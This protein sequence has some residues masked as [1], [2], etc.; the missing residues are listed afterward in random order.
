MLMSNIIN[1]ACHSS[2]MLYYEFV[3]SGGICLPIL[4]AFMTDL[5][6]DREVACGIMTLGESVLA[7]IWHRRGCLE[8]NL[9]LYF[10]LSFK[11]VQISYSQVVSYEKISVQHRT[12]AFMSRL[13]I[14]VPATQVISTNVVI[15]LTERYFWSVPSSSSHPVDT[16]WRDFCVTCSIDIHLMSG[17]LHPLISHVDSVI[18]R[19]TLLF[20]ARFPESSRADVHSF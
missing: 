8:F 16:Y 15:V 10:T 13:L 19:H 4:S 11:L 12:V 7:T 9:P 1:A 2:N 18:A 20:C 6:P 5:W 3:G 17:P 14:H